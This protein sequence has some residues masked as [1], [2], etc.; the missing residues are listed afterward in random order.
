MKI[1]D[2]EVLVK[3]VDVFFWMKM[4]SEKQTE[5][6]MFSIIDYFF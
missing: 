1:Y 6:C 2:V 3:N 4:V 5:N